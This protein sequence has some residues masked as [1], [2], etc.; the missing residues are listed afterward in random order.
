MTMMSHRDERIQAE[1]FESEVAR[2]TIFDVDKLAYGWMLNQF[3]EYDMNLQINEPLFL[4][5]YLRMCYQKAVLLG[6]RP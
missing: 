3:I 1:I 5:G 6:Q 4:L 2:F